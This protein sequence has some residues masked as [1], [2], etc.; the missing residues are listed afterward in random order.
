M[1]GGGE[2]LRGQLF[3]ATIELGDKLV[4]LAQATPRSRHVG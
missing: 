4:E 2:E 1:V 3:G